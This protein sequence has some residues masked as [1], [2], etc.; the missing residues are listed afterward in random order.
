MKEWRN[1]WFIG[2]ME[3][4]DVDWFNRI[5]Q[6]LMTGTSHASKAHPDTVAQRERKER[7]E[8]KT[9][10]RWME[11]LLPNAFHL[12]WKLLVESKPLRKMLASQLSLS[13]A[14]RQSGVKRTVANLCLLP[15]PKHM[16]KFLWE[17]NLRAKFLS[18]TPLPLGGDWCTWYK[19]L[20]HIEQKCVG[21]S[22]GHAQ[23]LR[24]LP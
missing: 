16:Y 7:T 19:A 21:S 6:F 10:E 22:T 1:E 15:A 2:W 5:P 17:T 4:G 23:V 11:D 24:V 9:N 14:S 18:A 8:V 12:I 13:P 3:Q 20:H